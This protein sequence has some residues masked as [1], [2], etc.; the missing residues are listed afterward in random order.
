MGQFGVGAN[1]EVTKGSSGAGADISFIILFFIAGENAAYEL[2][3]FRGPSAH[4]SCALY[5]PIG[6][7]LPRHC[8]GFDRAIDANALIRKT[9]FFQ[10]VQKNFQFG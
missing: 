7:R 5:S 4:S 10:L 2:A 3:V 8:N 6:D 1:S 9:R